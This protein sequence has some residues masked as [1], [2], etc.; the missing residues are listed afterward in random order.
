MTYINKYQENNSN[1]KFVFPCGKQCIVYSCCNIWCSK[2]FDYCNF[3][4]D[5][6]YTMSAD[7]IHIYRETTPNMIR[8]KIQNLYTYNKRIV[9]PEKYSMKRTEFFKT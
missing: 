4:A 1:N 8:R 7:Q 6:M 3:I 5:C 2:V 9:C